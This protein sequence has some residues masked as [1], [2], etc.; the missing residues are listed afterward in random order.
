MR[1]SNLKLFAIP[2]IAVLVVGFLI[3]NDTQKTSSQDQS[4][5]V[6]ETATPSAST[7]ASADSSSESENNDGS[8][9]EILSPEEYNQAV[10]DYNQRTQ[11]KMEANDRRAYYLTY[12]PYIAML[13]TEH[14]GTE[15]I[16][17]K[18]F[19]YSDYDNGEID[20]TINAFEYGKT[21]SDD[22]YITYYRDESNNIVGVQYQK[23]TAE[24]DALYELNE[25]T[26]D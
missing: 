7:S 22:Y 23:R 25:I 18:V 20:A 17:D 6:E 2:V 13:Q 21:G 24:L 14:S 5:V 10:K 19:L 11:E 3:Y 15:S 12:A 1:N 26:G 4:S 8:N 16:E 9:A